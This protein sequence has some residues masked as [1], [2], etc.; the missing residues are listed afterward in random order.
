MSFQS[1]DLG[2]FFS[3][4]GGPGD[5]RELNLGG[6]ISDTE[7]VHSV[8][9]NWAP[10]IPR[11][12]V[13]AIG[14]SGT[15]HMYFPF[16]IKN[17]NDTVTITDVKLVVDHIPSSINV[18]I[19]MG[20][21]ASSLNGTATTIANQT[22]APSGV[23]FSNPQTV[24]IFNYTQQTVWNVA[25]S[26]APGDH[27]ALWVHLYGPKGVPSIPVIKFQLKCSFVRPA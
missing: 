12:V 13:G 20:F 17:K 16:Y 24:I 10:D 25:S 9:Q 3:T 5:D 26:M 7:I 22:T 14:T 27:Q 21:D 2:F 19:Q 8:N 6:A 11:T 18:N 1:T 23:T 15:W 4:G